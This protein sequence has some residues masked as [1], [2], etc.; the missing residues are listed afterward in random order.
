MIKDQ[1]SETPLR[2]Y[3]DSNKAV[4]LTVTSTNNE[5]MMTAKDNKYIDDFNEINSDLKLTAL[6]DYS[7]A[8]TQR[9]NL[10]LENGGTGILL[11][12]IFLSIFLNIRLAFWVVFGLLS[13]L[14]ML[15]FQE[16]LILPLT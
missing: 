4:I 3:V 9:T 8:L 13:F 16:I 12:L 7:I 5:D 6:K 2:S 14:G 11:V 10:L 15:I 1:F